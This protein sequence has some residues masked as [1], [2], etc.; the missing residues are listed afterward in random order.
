MLLH[1][2]LLHDF[3]F[4]VL[5]CGAPPFCLPL[6]AGGF[7]LLLVLVLV[8]Q[9]HGQKENNGNYSWCWSSCLNQIHLE[10]MEKLKLLNDTEIVASRRPAPRPSSSSSRRRRQSNRTRRLRRLQQARRKLPPAGDQ[11]A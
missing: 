1:T 3:S 10:C 4:L 5:A 9:F 11:P 6:L 7:L 2:T 8:L